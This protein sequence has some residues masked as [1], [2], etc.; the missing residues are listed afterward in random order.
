VYLSILNLARKLH[1]HLNNFRLKLLSKLFTVLELPLKQL[2]DLPENIR[3]FEIT[4][5]HQ[6]FG[7][8]ALIGGNQK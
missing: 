8:G 6:G 3:A 1:S 7:G 2:S 5:C 4:H